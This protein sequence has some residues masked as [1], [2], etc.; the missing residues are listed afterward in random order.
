MNYRQYAE[1]IPMILPMYYQ[2]PG[3]Q[4]AY[5]VPNQYLFGSEMMVAAVTTPCIKA[6]NMAKTVVWLPEGDWYDI[7]T[8]LRYRGGRRMNLYRDITA[9]PVFVKAGTILPFQDDYMASADENP[10]QLHLYVY[11]GADGTFTLYEDDNVTTGYQE[12]K[13]VRTRYE[14]QEEEGRLRICSASGETSLIP[15]RGIMPSLSVE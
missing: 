8:G 3:E 1:G 6:L 10:R 15:E 14:W 5:K 13:C 7:F 12:G 4:E 9:I 2:Y 11:V